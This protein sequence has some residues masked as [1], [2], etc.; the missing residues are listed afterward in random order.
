VG[1]AKAAG[2]YGASLYPA[3]FAQ[4]QGYHQL[5]WTD[6]K[7]HKFIEESGTM[8]IL[9]VIDDVLITPSE[10]EDTILR[11]VTKRS[12]IE[13][14]QHWGIKVEERKISVEE[15][16][17]AA[18]SGRLQDAFGAGTAATLAQIALIGHEGTDY[19]LPPVETRTVS[20]RLKAYLS[21]LKI[22]QSDDIFNWN[23]FV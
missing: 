12:I 22:G 21:G 11:G 23:Y 16:I 18:K 8:N 3:K 15:V 10:E 2:N 9:F 19:H 17:N 5:V 1:R 7:E 14:A 6:A 13:L 4:D 20:N